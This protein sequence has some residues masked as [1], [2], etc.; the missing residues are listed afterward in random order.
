MSLDSVPG[1]PWVCLPLFPPLPLNQCNHTDSPTGRTLTLLTLIH[2]SNHSLCCTFNLL[3]FFKSGFRDIWGAVQF[4][5]Q[6][7]YLLFNLFPKVWPKSE[8]PPARPSRHLSCL[9]LHVDS[10]NLQRCHSHSN[11]GGKFISTKCWLGSWLLNQ[12]DVYL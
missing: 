5:L 2:F 10:W 4:L 8:V 3:T 1:C 11:I 7:H 9:K 12:V 6:Q